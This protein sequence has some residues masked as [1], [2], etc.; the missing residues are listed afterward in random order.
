MFDVAAQMQPIVTA[1]LLTEST[2]QKAL[3]NKLESDQVA[4]SQQLQTVAMRDPR[5]KRTHADK[6]MLIY[7]MQG[8]RC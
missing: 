2:M 8:G 4:L 6:R 7:G 1:T 3:V 5:G